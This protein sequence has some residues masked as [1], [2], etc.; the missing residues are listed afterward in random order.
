M[1]QIFSAS[2]FGAYFKKSLSEQS[3]NLLLRFTIITGLLTFIMATNH[4]R[5]DFF[6]NTAICFI[7]STVWASRFSDYFNTRSRKI[8]FLLT[9]ASQF[10]K[11][12]S[13][14]IH[15]FIIVPAAYAV[16]LLCS[17][18]IATLLIAVFTLSSPEWTAPFSVFEIETDL[19]ATFC[20]S[21]FSAMAYYILGAT[22]WTRNSFLKTTAM[23]FA[24][25]ISLSML[26]SIG[27]TSLTIQQFFISHAIEPALIEQVGS[28]AWDVLNATSLLFMIAYLAIAY[29]RISE[30]EVNETKH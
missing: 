12:L 23:T 15:T 22:I 6:T 20:V 8:T 16:T 19:L 5:L 21:Y 2:R 29:M 7:F 27:F 24:I 17:Q 13:A 10:E 14:V 30:F 26:L 25:G 11:F 1:N 18:Y 9:P 4:N 3:R 28:I